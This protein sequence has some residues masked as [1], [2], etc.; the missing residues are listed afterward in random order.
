ME[1]VVSDIV[2]IGISELSRDKTPLLHN[3][4]PLWLGHEEKSLK[5]TQQHQDHQ[6][7]WTMLELVSAVMAVVFLEGREMN[8]RA[9]NSWNG[10][11]GRVMKCCSGTS[12]SRKRTNSV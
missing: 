9:L 1:R 6:V 4:A 2:D 8:K 12:S 10:R 7:L 5:G 3:V 11:H